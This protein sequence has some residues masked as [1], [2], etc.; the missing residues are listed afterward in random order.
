VLP[1]GPVTTGMTVQSR[2]PLFAL[3]GL[4]ACVTP[5]GC[6]VVAADGYVVTDFPISLSPGVAPG[7]ALDGCEG[8]QPPEGRLRG[9]VYDIPLETRRLPDFAAMSPAETVCL[10]RLYVTPRRS[11]YPGFPGLNERFRWFAVDLEGSFTVAQEGLFYFRLISDDGSRL[12]LDDTLVIDN[13]GYHPP[14]MALG[15]ARLTAGRHTI[16]VPY[17]QGPGPMALVLD[18]ARPGEPY[19]VLR[20]D[21]PL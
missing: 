10:D 15:A 20:V 6:A 1:V 12:F 5:I 4:V 14:R 19:H 18:V 2:L 16:H 13:D 3:L 8:D 11:V 7:L 21:R 17:W 9:R